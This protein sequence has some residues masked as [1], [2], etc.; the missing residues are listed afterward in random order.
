MG[1]FFFT[2]EVVKVDQ[3][4]TYSVVE[5][6]VDTDSF[7]FT[8]SMVNTEF[9]VGGNSLGTTGPVFFYGNGA[10]NATVTLNNGTVISAPVVTFSDGTADY[11]LFQAS[12]GASLPSSDHI[13]PNRVTD[14]VTAGLVQMQTNEFYDFD[15]FHLLEGTFSIRH[16][17][18]LIVRGT[19]VSVAD[20]FAADDDTLF[21][22]NSSGGSTETGQAP[23]IY[24]SAATLTP[25]SLD[26]L[27]GGSTG[28]TGT[29]VTVSYL[30]ASGGSGSFEAIEHTL[31]STKT[32]IPANGHVN[33]ANIVSVTS[34]VATVTPVDGQTYGAFG[35][36]K[37]LIV[38]EGGAADD[39]LFGDLGNDELR[40]K[41]GNDTLFGDIGND[42]LF[43]AQG[44][45]TLF[46]GADADD[47]QGGDGNDTLT[48]GTGNDTLDGGKG[49]DV[50]KGN[51]GV[52]VLDG[53]KGEDT[54]RG[55]DGNDTLN[56]G[57]NAD[58]LFGGRNQD[59]LNGGN[60]DDVLNGDQGADTLDGGKGSDTL[61]GG[62]GA[63]IFVFKADGATDT[64]TDYEDGIDK[65]DLDVSF[66]SLTIT[67]VAPGEVHITHSGETLIVLDGGGGTLLAADFTAADFL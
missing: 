26:T 4:G 6:T 61:A 28:T 13:D 64:I 53:K 36:N 43:G 58:T 27:S 39:D 62:T 31:F 19:S 48:G 33:L 24:S 12:G 66:A 50:L 14:I 46:G 9:S 7:G 2:G 15:R 51:A 10:N 18:A 44:S 8:S 29:L 16:G 54:L 17:D 52:D 57:N 49:R 20:I 35:L 40:G 34:V 65:I 67:D 37:N 56:G 23:V 60:G 47:L 3:N 45:D 59:T 38:Q 42:V 30:T 21:E 25:V 55:H 63:D 1:A 41:N 32:Y 22:F 11:Y 5:M